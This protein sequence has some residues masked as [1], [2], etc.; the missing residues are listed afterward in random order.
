MVIVFAAL[1]G[2]VLVNFSANRASTNLRSAANQ[3]VE[4][5]RRAQALTLANQKQSICIADSLVCGSGSGCDPALP[6]G[7]AD[8]YVPSYGVKLDEDGNGNR[9]AIFADY[10]ED[11]AYETGEAI[12]N[13][14]RM[15]P[16][17][18]VIQSIT[19][20]GNDPVVYSSQ[21]LNASP[22]LAC[23]ADCVTTVVLESTV[24]GMTRTVT[25]RKETGAVSVE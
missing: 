25:V 12:P 8:T 15:L 10:D 3:L 23:A 14:I 24:T 13:G 21:E 18:I 7:C 9:Y 2:A 5:I 6:G 22:F 20:P 11:G 16:N 17:R 19:P 1:S 4:D